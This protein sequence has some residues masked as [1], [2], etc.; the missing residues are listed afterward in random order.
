MGQKT[1]AL[2]LFEEIMASPLDVLSRM[3]ATNQAETE[4]L[5]F[6]GGGI[7]KAIDQAKGPFSEVLSAFA[8]TSGGVLV[9]GIDARRDPKTIIDG[10]SAQ[11]LV[12]NAL[13]F[14]EQL[15]ARRL[16]ATSDHIVGLRVE[17][18]RSQGDE[19]FV[20]CYVPEGQN[21]PY[22]AEFAESKYFLRIGDS[23]AIM[24][25]AILRTMFYPQAVVAFDCRLWYR[26]PS[27]G[28]HH[29]GITLTNTGTAS[30]EDLY[31][32]LTV[33]SPDVRFDTEP[34]LVLGDNS[35]TAERS[36]HPG[37]QLVL[38]GATGSTLSSRCRIEFLI[39]CKNAAPRRYRLIIYYFRVIQHTEELD[40]D[41]IPVDAE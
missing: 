28:E 41:E 20:V 9:F 1:A 38:I 13:E 24:P 16:Q 15:W 22:R 10:A 14:R 4:Y 30:A 33:T 31:I 26:N 23:N 18:I 11:I 2:E 19:G 25:H 6:K 3:V 5:E 35:L 8:N 32:K 36:I 7:A 17:A 34:P 39:F 27:G 21:K 40:F 12:A 37:E 29:Y